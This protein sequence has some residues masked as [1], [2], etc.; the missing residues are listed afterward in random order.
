LS[1]NNGDVSI[2]PARG[3]EELAVFVDVTQRVTDEEIPPV[4]TFEHLLATEP[5][6]DFLLARFDGEPVGTGVGRNSSISGC[7]YAMARVLPDFRRRGVGAALYATL[8]EQARAAGREALVGRIREDDAASLAFAEHRGFREISREVPVVLELS[9]VEGAEPTPPPGIE[10]VSLAARPDLAKGAWQVDVET[11]PE[12]PPGDMTASSF[13]QWRARMLEA[14]HALA[15][16]TFVALADDEVV[17]YAALVQLGPS[18]RTAE[19]E[20]TAVRRPW[21]RRG[22]ATALKR[23]QIAWAKANGYERLLTANDEV[24]SAMRAVNAKLGYRP[25][26]GSV[27]LRGPLASA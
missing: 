8:S 13:E 14:P 15:Q 4:E 24:N 22:I 11:V 6:S 10:L 23:A 16:A 26:P 18:G 12:L 5:E 9:C 27:F 7:Y 21:R 1:P 3:R 17:G 2:Q 19:H 25:A 20:L